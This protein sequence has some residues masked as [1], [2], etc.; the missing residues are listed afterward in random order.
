ME[1]L[2]LE[3]L[4]L[5]PLLISKLEGGGYDPPSHPPLYNP[6]N[7]YAACK[8]VASLL[9]LE[10]EDNDDYNKPRSMRRRQKEKK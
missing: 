4:L 3:L 5:L 7:Y 2:P 6:R 10:V 9:V 8:Y 1:I